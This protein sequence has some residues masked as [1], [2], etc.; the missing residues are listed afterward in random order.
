[1]SVKVLSRLSLLL[2]LSALL[3]VG[4]A[5]LGSAAGCGRGGNGDEGWAGCTPEKI[6]DRNYDDPQEDPRG[7]PIS[8]DEL[9]QMYCVDRYPDYDG[10]TETGPWDNDPESLNDFYYDT[11]PIPDFILDD[12]NLDPTGVYIWV[13]AV[14][15]GPDWERNRDQF[16]YGP[17]GAN[18]ANW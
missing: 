8:E 2:V 1:M 10:D 14:C 4:V 3:I 16:G 11:R 9:W 17:Q 15:G 13:W 12:M 7:N 18:F 6:P 5:T